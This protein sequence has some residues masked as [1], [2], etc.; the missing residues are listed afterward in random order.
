MR[1]TMGNTD[2]VCLES[3]VHEYQTVAGDISRLLCGLNY[4][5]IISQG[6]NQPCVFTLIFPAGFTVGYLTKRL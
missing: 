2:E 6:Q 5:K 3:T 1:S 4:N